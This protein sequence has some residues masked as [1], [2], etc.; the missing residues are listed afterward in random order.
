MDR[1]DIKCALAKKDFKLTD[2]AD[3]FDVTRCAITL[4]VKGSIKSER[5]QS[6]IAEII[7]KP[8]HQIWPKWYPK[9]K[10]KSAH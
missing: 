4:A 1:H 5:I 8:T 2:I 3:E 7:S 6:R 10:S 9:P